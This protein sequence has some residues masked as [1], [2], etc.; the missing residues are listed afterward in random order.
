M[1]QKDNLEKAQQQQ[2]Q[3]DEKKILGKWKS[4]EEALE[5]LKNLEQRITEYGEDNKFL[6]AELERRDQE[7]AKLRQFVEQKGAPQ[8]TPEAEPDPFAPTDE[9][10]N[11]LRTDLRKGLAA[12]NRR[13]EALRARVMDALLQ[14]KLSTVKSTEDYARSCREAFYSANKDLVG[15]ELLVGAVSAQVA[16][17]NPRVP[18][19]LLLGRIAERTR[20]ELQKLTG[21][22]RAAGTHME[23][24]ETRTETGQTNETPGQ[25]ELK[26]TLKAYGFQV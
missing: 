12:Y 21:G 15:K 16:A 1:D 7:L 19:H 6:Q 14:E 8:P 3:T 13:V 25:A 22:T 10:I 5:A 4:E 2:T 17:E 26:K 11:L 23:G 9:E 18:L 24:G 20:L